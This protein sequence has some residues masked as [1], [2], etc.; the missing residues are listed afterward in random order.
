MDDGAQID[1]DETLLEYLS[2]QQPNTTLMIADKWTPQATSSTT[3]S[4]CSATLTPTESVNPT[5]HDAGIS[6]T[7]FCEVLPNY[8]LKGQGSPAG[9]QHL[10]K[11][12]PKVG[13]K[14]RASLKTDKN[15]VFL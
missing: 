10:N 6:F 14:R 11:L 4:N 13:A 7:E 12:F 3:V 9:I 1:D 2:Q 15:I 5:T 8:L